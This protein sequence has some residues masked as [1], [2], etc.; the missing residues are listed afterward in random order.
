MRL[1]YKVTATRSSRE[2]LDLF[3]AQ[4]DAFD[5]LLTD[6]TM[7]DLTGIDLAAAV[8]RLRLAKVEPS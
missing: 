3:R 2:A 7:P 5:L 1:G 4:P 6:Y 8:L